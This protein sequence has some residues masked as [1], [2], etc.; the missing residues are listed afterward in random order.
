MMEG[1]ATV[2]EMIDVMSSGAGETSGASTILCLGRDPLGLAL[3]RCLGT[4]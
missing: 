2:I 4:T 3:S 1:G